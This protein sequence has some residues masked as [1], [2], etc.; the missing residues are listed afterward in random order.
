MEE[1]TNTQKEEE[2]KTL[3]EVW[4]YVQKHR[5]FISNCKTQKA[6]LEYFH[7]FL[8]KIYNDLNLLYDEG[9]LQ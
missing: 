5:W 7:K 9:V 6:K 1:Q 2:L 3:Q 8:Y 4:E